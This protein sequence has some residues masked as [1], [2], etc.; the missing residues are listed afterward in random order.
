MMNDMRSLLLV[1]AFL[2][3][4]GFAQDR[5]QSP[6]A[7]AR[8]APAPLPSSACAQQWIK[9]LG[10]DNYRERLEAENKL[11]EMG[12]KARQPLQA[13][14]EADRDGEAQWRAKRLLRQLQGAEREP[15]P[16]LTERRRGDREPEV[17]PREDGE[18][19]FDSNR[20][21]DIRAEFD[22]L[23]RRM[24]EQHGLDV[25]RHRFF[26][27]SFFRDLKSQM[28]Q[29]SSGQSVSVQVTPDGVHV[30]VTETG[31]DGKP[32][33]KVYDAKD[34]E[35]FHKEHPGVLPQNEGGF[36]LRP[37]GRIGLGDRMDE[38]RLDVGA[39]Q[40]GFDLRMLQPRELPF[41]R[42][43][44]TQQ[45]ELQPR[46]S[47]PGT[48]NGETAPPP[49]GARLGVAI[50]PIPDAVREYLELPEDAGL[51]V[52]SVQDDTLAA[53]LELRADDIVLRIN[54]AD[55]ATPAD[56][57][58]ALSAIQKGNNVKVEYLRRGQ[59]REA[60]TKKQ[61]DVVPERGEVVP[62]KQKRERESIR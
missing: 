59:R 36:A 42:G 50:K 27:D 55:V 28:Q 6:S 43:N 23:F 19:R 60:E 7:E 24:E 44:R 41:G 5:G 57:Q 45:F 52:Q 16:G 38:M 2:T 9:Q 29:S 10:S 53:A 3:A 21:D 39:P 26:D 32:E 17:Q 25:P 34:M 8:T 58:K 49:Q 22:R 20:V 31:A 14:A 61:H 15:Q 46:E 18:L 62:G 54:G 11:R 1:S 37:F 56:V 40:R 48:S 35:S 47:L 13:A 51:M 4:T 12:E 30:E 33:T